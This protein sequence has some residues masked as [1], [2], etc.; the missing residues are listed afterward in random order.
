[1]FSEGECFTIICVCIHVCSLVLYII[2]CI[3]ILLYNNYIYIY[4]ECCTVLIRYH[5]HPCVCVCTPS[6]PV[7]VSVTKQP[8]HEERKREK[9]VQHELKRCLLMLQWGDSLHLMLDA[10]CDNVCCGEGDKVSSSGARVKG[11]YARNAM[12]CEPSMITKAFI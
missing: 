5:L 9:C 3:L 12:I 2:R 6:L 7:T 10:V 4:A 1:M 11:W 8:N